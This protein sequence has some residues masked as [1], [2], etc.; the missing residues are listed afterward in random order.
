[1]TSTVAYSAMLTLVSLSSAQFLYPRD[2]DTGGMSLGSYMK[3]HPQQQTKP[4]PLSQPYA[5][6]VN[7]TMAAGGTRPDH[8]TSKVLSKYRMP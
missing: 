5:Q 7:K 2:S 6:P 8:S 3:P 1:M 4:H